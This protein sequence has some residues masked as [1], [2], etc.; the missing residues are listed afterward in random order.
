MFRDA[1]LQWAYFVNVAAE[2]F[3]PKEKATLYGAIKGK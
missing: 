1:V 2:W 3:S